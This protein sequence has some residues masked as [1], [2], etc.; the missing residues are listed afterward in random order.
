MNEFG[1]PGAIIHAKRLSACLCLFLWL[2]IG[3]RDSCAESPDLTEEVKE[4]RQTVQDL[5]ARV[6]KLESMLEN[7]S[8]DVPTEIEDESTAEEKKPDGNTIRTFW[9]KGL[10]LESENK[11]LKMKVGGRFDN[12]WYTGEIDD[13]DF[14][15]G[16][17]FRR[18]RLRVEGVFDDDYIFDWQ[19]EFA[20]DGRARWK[21]LYVG[22]TGMD[23]A[24]IRAG[25]FK[26]PFGLEQ[27]MRADHMTFLERSP[28]DLLVPGR[29]VGAMLDQQILDK[30]ATWAIGV[31]QNTNDF[32]DG[33]DGDLENGD[34]D[35][36]A[37]LTG[38]PWY[39]DEGRQLL[40]LGLGYSHREWDNDP[41]RLQPR[42]SFSRGDTLLDTGSFNVDDFDLYGAESALVLGPL[43]FQSE[44][45]LA[46]M[47]STFFGNCDLSA[48]YAQTGYFL[49]G[50]HHPYRG[51]QFT[52]VDPI[53][54]FRED[55]GWGAWEM[56]F[57]YGWI[58]LDDTPV[59]GATGG[60]LDDF[61]LGLNWYLNSNVRLMW[62]YVH[63]E[64]NGTDPEDLEADIYQMRFELAF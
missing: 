39:R 34:W 37:R 32:G 44:Y 12:D 23:W 63:T 60:E 26:E 6:V 33:E 7:S 3:I 46:D 38:L 62:N 21:N 14:P 64:S 13:G 30:R 29:E 59:L 41:Y 43:S 19:Y 20:G 24:T 48:F 40:H 58:D 55:G 61:V 50:E 10:W 28:L 22:Y 1:E 51:G 8:N 16:T 2:L 49:T 42:G 11:G 52:R 54:N 36:T 56:A 9:D 47:N 45:V 5:R 57:R 35:V 4:L 27:M 25:Q 31:F 53:K 17:R 18:A 15:S